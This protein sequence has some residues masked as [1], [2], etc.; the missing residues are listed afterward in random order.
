MHGTYFASAIGVSL[1]GAS[2]VLIAQDGTAYFPP[3]GEQ[4]A[5]VCEDWNTDAQVAVDEFH[6]GWFGPHLRVA[7]EPSLYLASRGPDG[8]RSLRFDW[9]RS[10]HPTIFVRIAFSAEGI[11]TLT[12][13]ELLGAGGYSSHGVARR[14]ERPLSEV[15]LAALERMLA[16]GRPFE[17]SAVSCALGVDGAQWVLE[18][19]RGREYRVANQWSPDDGPLRELAAY[20]LSLTGWKVEPIY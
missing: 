13:T 11:A 9:F 4:P 3:P 20:L 18:E 14:I 17:R 16:N 19:V 15:E 6:A 2:V 10:F 12:A 7:E 5:Y 8:G 1:L